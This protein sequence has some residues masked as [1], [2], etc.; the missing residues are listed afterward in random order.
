MRPDFVTRLT[1]ALS[2][3]RGIPHLPFLALYPRHRDPLDE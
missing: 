2:V 1:S 3:K